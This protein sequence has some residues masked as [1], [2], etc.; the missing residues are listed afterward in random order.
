MKNLFSHFLSFAVL[1]VGTTA[2]LQSCDV[3]NLM[4]SFTEGTEETYTIANPNNGTLDVDDC[5]DIMASYVIKDHPTVSQID[6]LPDG[7]YQLV[8]TAHS[9]YYEA[10][11][12]TMQLRVG[13]MN[14]SV[15]MQVSE[16]ALLTRAYPEPTETNSYT[17][18][19]ATGEYVLTDRGWHVVGDVLVVYDADEVS[20]VYTAIKLPDVTKTDLD[21]RLCHSWLL[22]EVL[23]KLYNKEG[24]T[25]KLMFSYRLSE[26]DKRDYC[27]RQFDFLNTGAFHRYLYDGSNNGNGDWR[28]Q[29]TANQQLYYEFKYYS[30]D[31]PYP[32]RGSNVTTVYFDKNF[33]YMTEEVEALAEDMDDADGK[34]I[35]LTAE[36]LYRFNVKPAR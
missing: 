15:P 26:D 6:F 30:F 23:L 36:L 31:E 19:R 13:G 12:R 20:E 27:I 32:M 10:P 24:K 9:S 7:T 33:F 34:M 17:Y 16:P 4:N 11:R 2:M 14:V 3:E 21:K 8:S 29:N 25:P 5:A 18:D 35:K 22:D 1:T 28:W